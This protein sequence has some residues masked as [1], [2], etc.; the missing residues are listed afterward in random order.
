V[1]GKYLL[2]SVGIL[3]LPVS[4]NDLVS[5]FKLMQVQKGRTMSIAVPG[6]RNIA[7]VRVLALGI[8]SRTGFQV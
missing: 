5:G 6:Y 2:D 7:P 4:E 8:K 3:F 1:G